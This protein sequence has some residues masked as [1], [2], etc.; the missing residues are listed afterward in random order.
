[1]SK[2]YFTCSVPRSG[3]STFAEKWASERTRRMIVCS[4]NIRLAMHGQRYS[5]LAE[6]MVFAVKHVM[7]RASLDRGFDVLV[8]GTHSSDISIQ[9]LLE[10]RLDAEPIFFFDVPKLE[11]IARAIKTNQMD[12]IPAIERT[13]QNF[14]RITGGIDYTTD[15]KWATQKM[16]LH[17]EEI[18][19]KVRERHENIILPK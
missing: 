19:K 9:R 14:M 4:D 12:T 3:K 13:Y 7:I 1:M 16:L 5:A 18:R 11:C 17:I 2:L 15:V 8:D 6:T 10:I